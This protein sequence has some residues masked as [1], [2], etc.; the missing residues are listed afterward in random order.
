MYRNEVV[1]AIFGVQITLL[2]QRAPELLAA[3][4]HVRMLTLTP[5]Y[6]PPRCTF[7]QCCCCCALRPRAEEGP[8]EARFLKGVYFRM[9]SS[10]LLKE[11]TA[12][13]YLRNAQ[14]GSLCTR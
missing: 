7:W 14:Q 8:T 2:G 11:C 3:A 5:L 12:A 10:D 4:V 13:I 9:N 6:S 1:P